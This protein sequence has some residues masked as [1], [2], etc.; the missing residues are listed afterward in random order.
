MRRRKD[1][2]MSK[3]KSNINF[4]ISKEE[5]CLLLL[6]HTAYRRGEFITDVYMQRENLSSKSPSNGDFK[7]ESTDTWHGGGTSRSSVEVAVMAV[8]RRGSIVRPCQGEK[9]TSS[10]GI[11]TDKAKPFRISR[12]SLYAAYKKVSSNK[13][14]GG[15][16]GISMEAFVKDYKNHLYKLWNRMNSGSYMS[17]AVRLK[18]ISKKGG[19]LRPLGIPT[20]AD[21]IIQTVVKELMGQELEPLFDENSYGYRPGKSA[22]EAVGKAREMC[23]KYDWVIDFDIKGFFDN[24]PHELL[25]KAV[26]KHC[27]TRWI[28]LYIE[29]WLVAPL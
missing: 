9:L 22:I 18:E 13:G 12:Q 5:T 26:R 17:P 7:G 20:I 19:G 10:E 27:K 21:R 3:L 28:L 16:D 11:E 29:R 6:R 15:V 2:K 4:G 1:K 24:I 8:E 14:S 25:M 23:W